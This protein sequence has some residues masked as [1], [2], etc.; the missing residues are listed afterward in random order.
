MR[1]RIEAPSSPFSD[2]R[3]SAGVERLVQLGHEVDATHAGPRGRHAYLN[4]DDDERARSL[5][6]ALS[7]DADVVWLVRGGYGLTR[8]VNDLSLP[9]PSARTPALIGF[10]DATAL[11]CHLHARG[12]SRLIHGP[13]VTT[14]PHEPH[15]SVG[16]LTD[17][18]AGRARSIGGLRSL[19]GPVDVEGALVAANLCVLAHLVGTRSLPSL[20]GA[21]LVIEE[22]GERP[23]R[24]DRMLTQ[25]LSSG[26]LAGVRAVVCGDFLQCE[27]PPQSGVRD[28][29]PAPLEVVRE[30]LGARM[31][32]VV[33][34]PVGHRAPNFAIPFGVRARVV[35]DGASSRLDIAGAGLA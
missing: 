23:Y 28:P 5:S 9:T 27:E 2:D 1:V 7:S 35:G 29:A 31:P 22:I 10:S 32:V 24:I 19:T 3:L 4:G 14:L 20:D 12:F 25:L 17:I 18:L 34:A 13:L 8:I 26:A 33:G 16:H 15:E 11:L 21:V 30:R 6:E